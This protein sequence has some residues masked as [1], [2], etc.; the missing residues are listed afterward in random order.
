MHRKP[1]VE[2]TPFSHASPPLLQIRSVRAPA[3]CASPSMRP[4]SPTLDAWETSA[5]RRI[6][7]ASH[8][9]LPT[10]GGGHKRAK[11]GT[12]DPALLARLK[13]L[14]ITCFWVVSRACRPGGLCWYRLSTRALR[15]V[16]DKAY[17]TTNTTHTYRV[18][19]QRAGPNL[20]DGTSE[21]P[22]GG[23]WSG[24]TPS[25]GFFAVRDVLHGDTFV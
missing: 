5:R 19:I 7:H 12:F 17:H 9:G 25:P 8:H 23:G 10:S 11:K 4:A 13:I 14:G 1:C 6:L 2:R 21:C 3:C 16:A 24:V 22:H 18:A 15:T 20:C